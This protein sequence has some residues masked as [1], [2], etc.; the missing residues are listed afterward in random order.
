MVRQPISAASAIPVRVLVGLSCLLFFCDAVHR[1]HADEALP[2]YKLQVGQQLN[3]EGQN[4]FKYTDGADERKYHWQIMVVQNNSDGTYRLVIRSA[5]TWTSKGIDGK[6]TTE[7]E[8]V[9]YGMADIDTSGKLAERLGSFGYLLDPTKVLY[10]MP[11]TSAETSGGWQSHTNRTDVVLHYRKFPESNAD[12]LIMEIVEDRPENQ[13]YG[14]EFHDTATFDIA[15]GLPEKR[16]ITWKQTY[17]FN[18]QG[19]GELYL[20]SVQMHDADWAAKL[21]ADADLFF[22]VEREFNQATDADDA[23][24]ESFDQAIADLKTAKEKIHS[25]EFQKQIDQLLDNFQKY[26]KSTE[27]DLQN[28]KAL[29]GQPAEDFKTTDL[30]DKPQALA[31]YRGKVVLLDFWYRGCGW[32]IRSMP[33]LKKVAEHYQGQPVALLG[34]NTDHDLDNA[35]FVVDK[36]GLNYTNLK[37][38]GLL[39]KF[40]VRGFPTMIIIDQTGKIRDVH[41]GWSAT[42]EHDLIEKIDHLLAETK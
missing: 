41:V 33:A 10:T 15:R 25:S 14:F 28:R 3:Y 18:G 29:I 6:E 24:P 12:K 8:K 31:D 11:S 19:S 38:E 27:E 34:M 17:G 36:L 35:K 13:I 20:V 39:E 16:I 26:R 9:D 40:K 4:E 5:S 7:E 21:A 42:L 22:R 32:C 2:R 30:N 23:T 37:A 1:L